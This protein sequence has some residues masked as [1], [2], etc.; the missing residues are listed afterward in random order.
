[1]TINIWLIEFRYHFVSIF[2]VADARH[3]TNIV[4]ARKRLTGIAREVRRN[5][6]D[7]YVFLRKIPVNSAI[8]N[9]RD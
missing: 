7:H 9:T 8:A 1:M 6:A 2:V 5:A 3:N 4:V